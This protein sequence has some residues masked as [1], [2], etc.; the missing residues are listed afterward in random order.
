MSQQQKLR[1]LQLQQQQQQFGTPLKRL[2]T[3][4]SS[5]PPPPRSLKDLIAEYENLSSSSDDDEEE[6]YKGYG[7]RI[8]FAF[9]PS[10]TPSPS[11]SGSTISTYSLPRSLPPS[12]PP[13]PEEEE[14]ASNDID[15]ESLISKYSDLLPTSEQTNTF[16]EKLEKEL[17]ILETEK[18]QQ[19]I[20]QKY[21]NVVFSIEHFSSEFAICNGVLKKYNK[22][23]SIIDD[24]L[25]MMINDLPI[26]TFADITIE[27]LNLL[28]QV[29][30]NLDKINKNMEL[31]TP[32]FENLLEYVENVLPRNI[33]DINKRSDRIEKVKEQIHAMYD[34]QKKNIEQVF[35]FSQ[36]KSKLSKYVFGGGG[37]ETL[38]KMIATAKKEI[39]KK[40]AE[41]EEKEEEETEEEEEQKGNPYTNIPFTEKFFKNINNGFNT[42]LL[43]LD[44][45]QTAIF[46]GLNVLKNSLESSDDAIVKFNNLNKQLK[47]SNIRF[48]SWTKRMEQF[49]EYMEN[50]PIEIKV[51]NKKRMDGVKT[52]LSNLHKIQDKYNKN[53][54][55]L[56]EVKEKLERSSGINN[57]EQKIKTK[58]QQQQQQQQEKEL[59]RKQKK[60][61]LFSS[62]SA[63]MK[64][65]SDFM[66]SFGLLSL[67]K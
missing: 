58:K 21:A 43:N 26:T 23:Q 65:E 49:L 44:E 25:Q 63:S 41:A 51:D 35:K 28:K 39:S 3:Q 34:A 54:I 55:M 52:K 32:R 6:E 48:K 64:I 56:L 8:L 7:D 57:T 22:H 53:V 33:I 20:K 4:S 37:E 27:L 19:Q 29:G 17:Q 16:V 36:F 38:E 50:L 10:I 46:S 59:E 47:N 9:P 67:E 5:L 12:L 62:S 31:W 15:I 30:N 2:S 40:E 11:G 14:E 45:I 42:I 61:K 1:Q 18:H 66:K 13:S 24:K 60:T